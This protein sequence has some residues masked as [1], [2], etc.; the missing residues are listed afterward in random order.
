MSWWD[1]KNV[2]AS[3]SDQN[4]KYIEKLFEYMGYCPEPDY[5]YDGDECSFEEPDVYCCMSSV[6]PYFSDQIRRVKELDGYG[7][8]DLRNL[9]NALFPR[10]FIYLHS[11]SG[12]NTSDCWEN[13]NEVYNTDDMT[14]YGVDTYTD[15]GE[16]TYEPDIS[17]KARFI[18]EPPPIEYVNALIDISTNDDNEELTALL[19]ELVQKL[20]NKEIVYADDGSDTREVNK[21]YDIVKGEKV[22]SQIA[23]RHNLFVKIFGRVYHGTKKEIQREYED[24]MEEYEEYKDDLAKVIARNSLNKYIS[25]SMKKAQITTADFIAKDAKITFDGKYFAIGYGF[26]FEPEITEEIRIRGGL[27]NTSGVIRKTDFYVVDFESFSYEDSR[28]DLEHAQ[29]IQHLGFGLQI[30]TEYQLWKALF[31]KRNPILTEEELEDRRI[32][33]EA[34]KKAKEEEK[35]K[36]KKEAEEARERRK[37]ERLLREQEKQRLAAE[38]QKERERQQALKIQQ[39]QEE[40][41]RR[42]TEALERYQQRKQEKE[43]EAREKVER[44]R[45]ERQQALADADIKYAPGE[46]PEAIRRRLDSLFSKL[47]AAYP[48]RVISGLNKNHKHLGETVTALYRLLGYPD[49]TSMLESYG[50]TVDKQY[51]CGA[52]V[53]VDPVAVMDKLHKR[54]PDGAGPVNLQRLKEDN[55]DIP[56]KTLSNNSIEYFGKTLVAYLKAE[57]IVGGTEIHAP[58][59]DD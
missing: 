8:D 45:L 12:S 46:E 58:L 41:I 43:K 36:K 49:G 30:I 50:Y 22:K 10:T 37:A 28:K 39:Q 27:I 48:D 53:K 14:C 31:D 15:Y 7:V 51:K 3:S 13:H 42:E 23:P 19:L 34:Q 16:G 18:L 20:R 54:Y 52:P 11:A 17:W 21:K 38:R 25:K 5:S 55:P 9:L 26:H 59:K 4:I 40:A 24:T 33:A 1:Y 2:G 56:W 6:K 44:L 47:D 57:G 32:Q 29:E 35:R